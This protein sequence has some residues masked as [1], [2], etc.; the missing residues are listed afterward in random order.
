VT[1]RLMT[2]G[3]R[4]RIGPPTARALRG[5]APLRIRPARRGDLPALATLMAS[6]PLLGRYRTTRKSALAA[7]ARGRAAGDRLLVATGPDG[8]VVG[9]AWVLPSRILTGAAY[10]RLL[11]VA[12]DRQRAG[13]G[14][15][16]LAAAEAT[17]RAVAN[18]LVLLATTDNTGARRF[19]ERHGYRHVGD[20]PAFARAGLDEAL[21]WK[22]L[23][24]LGGRLPV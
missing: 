12:V 9:M 17:T 3:R 15:A 24:S 20:L 6:A 8:R 1:P 16:L 13:A 23:R 22:P 2:T 7:L 14:A 18:H 11:L 19:Y 10:L 21:Y 4:A 5:R